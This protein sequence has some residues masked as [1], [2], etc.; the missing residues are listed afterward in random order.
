MNREIKVRA[1]DVARTGAYT[2]L[3]YQGDMTLYDFL[4]EL[5]NDEV[6]YG[7]KWQLSQYTGLKDKNGKEIYEGGILKCF[8]ANIVNSL[9]IMILGV[10]KYTA[11][12]FLI[13]LC[14][15]DAS[16]HGIL[17]YFLN[18]DPKNYEVIGNIYENPE[19]LE[20]G[21]IKKI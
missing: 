20:K 8:V 15:K 6:E 12:E 14:E 4:H 5:H 7:C 2:S 13:Q 10:V 18:H 3:R 21:E 17:S 1:W 11:P 19:L 9:P 16:E